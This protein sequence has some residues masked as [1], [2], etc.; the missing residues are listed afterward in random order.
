MFLKTAVFGI[1]LFIA[2]ANGFRFIPVLFFILASFA[3]YSRPL[4][5]GPYNSR[6]AFLVLLCVSILGMKIMADSPLFFPGLFL[7]SFIFYLVLGIK[8]ILFV[9]RSRIYY[10]AA[11]LL[12][13]ALFIIFFLAD[14][15]SFY[16]FKYSGAIIASLLLF[17]E[18]LSIVSVFHFPKREFISAL[19]AAFITAQLLWAVALLPVGFIAAS[20]LMILF[21]L[22]LG[23]FLFA[24]FTG[25]LSK[26]F[27]IK[28]S[29][30]FLVLVLL[31]RGFSVW[32]S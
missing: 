28:Y 5:A 6:H 1:S 25:N 9:K 12:F 21:V 19:A 20:N 4:F 30:L 7:F 23:D 26:N 17:R 10:V 2:S 27:I 3:L 29:I 14:K 15:S 11:L 18:W 8:E 32:L 31:I 22:I 24:H 16:L 13:Y